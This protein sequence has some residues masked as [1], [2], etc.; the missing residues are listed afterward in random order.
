MA[1]GGAERA[2]VQLAEGLAA[3]GHQVDMVLSSAVGPR[4]AEIPEVVRT[5]DLGARRVAGSLWPLVRYLRRERPRALVSVL[6]HANVVAVAARRLARVPTRVVVVEQNTL[7]MVARHGS[8]RRDRSMP[9]IAGRAFLWADCVVGVSAGVVA[10]LRALLPSLPADRLR[11]VYNPVITDLTLQRSR[12]PV[13]HPWFAAGVPVF[14]A[15]GRLTAQK[16]FPALI[17]A[18]GRVRAEC[19]ARL[20]ILGEGPDRGGLEALVGELGLQDDVSLPGYVDNPF[21]FM[22]AA[23]AFVLSSRWEGLPSVLIEALACGRPV[24]ATDC[25]SGPRE[26]LAGGTYGRL[27]PVGDLDAL[28]AALLAAL[29]GEIQAPPPESWRPYTLE[30][31]VD[32]YLE[33]LT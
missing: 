11:V 28:A 23:T 20:L 13:D 30:A 12:A 8:T 4:M 33:L 27:V 9:V 6:D 21:A 7:S 14:L 16:D 17:R 2:A 19:D 32:A 24:I 18:F 5:V 3:R 10:D 29:A 26:I 31:V 1:G 22:S 15:V 25:P